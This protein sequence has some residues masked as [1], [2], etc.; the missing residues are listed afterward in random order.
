MDIHE[1]PFDAILLQNKTTI[2]RM[3]SG[4]GGFAM[5]QRRGFEPPTNRFVADYSIQL[6][7]RCKSLN[8]NSTSPLRFQCEIDNSEKTVDTVFSEKVMPGN[9]ES[10]ESP[11]RCGPG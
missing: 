4:D 1:Q 7:Y 2:N 3:R 5:V 9:P 10:I 8:Y 6:S 11:C